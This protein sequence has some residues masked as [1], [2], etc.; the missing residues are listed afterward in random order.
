MPICE[1]GWGKAALGGVAMARASNESPD[2]APIGARGMRETALDYAA[3]DSAPNADAYRCTLAN[4]SAQAIGGNP[5]FLHTVE[6]Q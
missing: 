3:P 5:K 2:M 1:R 6:R 4:M